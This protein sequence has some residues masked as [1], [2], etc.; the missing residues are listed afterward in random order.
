M[1]ADQLSAANNI[2]LNRQAK[3]P[4]YA[5][6]YDA[7]RSRIVNGQL[8]PDRR[9]PAVRVLAKALGINPGTVVSAYRELEKNGYIISRRGSGSFIQEGMADSLATDQAQIP[10]LPRLDAIDA[11]Q[12][13][14]DFA[15]YSLNPDRFSTS[16]FKQAVNHI[17]DRDGGH[18]FVIEDEMGYYPL[19][20]SLAAELAQ[21]WIKTKPQNI[22]ITS[23][24]QQA[25]DICARALIRQGDCVIVQNP[26][27]PGAVDA[28]KACGAKVI[29][30]NFNHGT[31]IDELEKM[32]KIIQPKIL[33]L[34]PNLQNP[35]TNSLSRLEKAR[36]IG[37]A[38]RHDFWIIEDDYGSGLAYDSN[39]LHTM[40]EH[41]PDDRIIYVR[42][43]SQIFASGMR[44]GYL[45]SPTR[46][47]ESFAG[48][49]R[50]ADISTS[51]L[52]Q[53]IFDYYLRN[54]LWRK[55]LTGLKL[56]YHQQ[57][58]AAGKL[59][60]E[61]FGDR[62]SWQPADGAVWFWLQLNLPMTAAEFC[63]AAQNSGVLIENGD[64][65]YIHAAPHNRIRL[66]LA[67]VKEADIA[68]GIKRLAEL[69]SQ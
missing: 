49:K 30:L 48:V 19:R 21:R 26:T 1:N 43:L 55:H 14:I 64:R 13:F 28:F 17:L 15:S 52:S 61:S 33:Y 34:M 67:P 20:E 47:I 7:L 31:L 4:L 9:L 16:N 42:S 51:G 56:A 59:L 5:Q 27:Y 11:N 69:V 38:H 62:L 65:Y 41:D 57:Y 54:R 32:L 18:A 10:Y 40:K 6:L 25:I 60:A 24:S 50:I 68:V 29:G 66:S 45:V 46:L 8:A 39:T 44:L 22:Q 3:E 63:T 2:R 53:R 23:G 12:H 36:I 37:L 58:Q 35:T